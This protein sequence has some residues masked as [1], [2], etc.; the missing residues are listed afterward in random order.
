MN[1]KLTFR[2][3]LEEE[4]AGAGKNGPGEQKSSSKNERDTVL[5]TLKTDQGDRGEDEG[6]NRGDDLQISLQSGIG[7]KRNGPQPE[8]KKHDQQQSHHMPEDWCG[9]PTLR[10]KLL[11]VA[12]SRRCPTCKPR[13]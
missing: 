4:H 9:F 12:H 3:N 10:I 2:G 8:R 6:Q 1:L 5:S 7:L 13:A 11:C